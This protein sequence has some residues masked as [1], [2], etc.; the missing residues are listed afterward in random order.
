MKYI[1]C[2]IAACLPVLGWEP[3][4]AD[5]VTYVE[6]VFNV[7]GSIDGINFSNQ[8]LLLEAT[9]DTNNIFELATP[10]ICCV[11]NPVGTVSFVIFSGMTGIAAGTIPSAALFPNEVFSGN[12]GGGFLN[13]TNV[14]FLLEDSVPVT[15]LVN[16]PPGDFPIQPGFVTTGNAAFCNNIPII[17]CTSDPIST[18]AGPLVLVANN[19]N[20]QGTSLFEAFTPISAVPSPIAGAGL[21]G[22]ILASGGLLGRWRRRQKT[23]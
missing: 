5:P 21:P 16:L 15:T 20:N 19:N 22:L 11:F 6:E 10:D 8:T 4:L 23:A 18:S 17:P 13:N 3:A 2:L 9:G 1:I 7:S 14:G 12:F